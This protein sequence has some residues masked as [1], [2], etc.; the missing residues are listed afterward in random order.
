MYV[1]EGQLPGEGGGERGESGPRD[2]RQWC[3]GD[4]GREN[5]YGINEYEWP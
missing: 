1:W 5:E 4:S 2:I 3:F